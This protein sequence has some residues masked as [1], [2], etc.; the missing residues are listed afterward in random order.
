M[1]PEQRLIKRRESIMLVKASPIVQPHRGLLMEDLFEGLV[2][3]IFGILAAPIVFVAHRYFK[4]RNRMRTR[5]LTELGFASSTQVIRH[6]LGETQRNSY[7][8]VISAVLFGLCTLFMAWIWVSSSF[9]TIATVL[10]SVVA[11]CTLIFIWYYRRSYVEF[12]LYEFMRS[13][14]GEGVITL[15][16]ADIDAYT[17][18]YNKFETALKITT[19]SGISFELDPAIQD[20]RYLCAMIAMR[21]RSNRWPDPSSDRDMSVVL[22]MMRT[23][24]WLKFLL[25]V[26]EGSNLAANNLA[27]TQH[28]N[29]RYTH[30]GSELF[31]EAKRQ[32]GF[33]A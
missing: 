21:M 23:Q 29:T 18:T 6:T 5:Q 7:F 22:H 30:E 13:R 17:F 33:Y 4:R 10:L 11:L 20:C 24:H 32:L 19:V 3:I 28:R 1:F 25:H 16:Y 31:E 12:R 15:D 9:D 14:L 26:R 2:R 8:S 27:S